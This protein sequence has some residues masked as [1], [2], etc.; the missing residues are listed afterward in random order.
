MHR[1]QAVLLL[2]SSYAPSRS[3]WQ[4]RRRSPADDPACPARRVDRTGCPGSERAGACRLPTAGARCSHRWPPM[5][6]SGA[7][8]CRQRCLPASATL[9]HLAWVACA[10]AGSNSG[11]GPRSWTALLRWP[12]GWRLS[13]LVFLSLTLIAGALLLCRPK[14][15][16]PPLPLTEGAQETLRTTLSSV[17][18]APRYWSGSAVEPPRSRD[19][20]PRPCP[21][22]RSSSRR[23]HADIRTPGHGL[24]QCAAIC[25]RL[26]P[27]SV[28]LVCRLSLSTHRCLSTS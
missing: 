23:D 17:T 7:A 9:L 19:W 14:Q 25:A 15:V 21:S 1:R 27:L 3:A 6:W 16:L 4:P 13:L 20:V 22:S 28:Q 26:L 24:R 5:A 8:G 11:S 18:M 10:A 2:S 12:A